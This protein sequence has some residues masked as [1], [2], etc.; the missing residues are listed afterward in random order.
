[1]CP[2]VMSANSLTAIGGIR[3]PRQARKG[4]WLARAQPARHRQQ[5]FLQPQVRR[6]LRLARLFDLALGNP[7]VFWTMGEWLK[8]AVLKSVCG[9]TRTWV[10]I[11]PPDKS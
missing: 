11:P 1:A 7:V 3:V 4:E 5:L 9:V 2:L 6:S 10:R 8:P